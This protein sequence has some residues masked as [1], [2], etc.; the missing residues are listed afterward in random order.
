MSPRSTAVQAGS[1]SEAVLTPS[2]SSTRRLY[3]PSAT[4]KDR[5]SG[6]WDHFPHDFDRDGRR[7]YFA[8]ANEPPA[9]PLAKLTAR[10]THVVKA[11]ALGHSNKHI[12]YELG[13][14]P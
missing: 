14:G 3:L 8:R 1:L 12:A 13:I 10:E 11:A 2:G 5:K 7:Y 6:T 9:D 4:T